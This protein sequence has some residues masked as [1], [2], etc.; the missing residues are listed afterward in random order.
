MTTTKS[1][2]PKD[3]KKN[4]L[5]VDA[6]DQIV[7]RLATQ[8]AYVLRGKHKPTYTPHVDC[9]DNVVIINAEKIRFTGN[10]WKA[11]EYYHHS[12]FI[13]GIK[14]ARAE[15]LRATKPERILEIA[16]KGMLPKNKLGRHISSN[17]KVYAGTE[18]PHAAQ[19][20]QPIKPRTATGE[21]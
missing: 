3:V 8:V 2:N 13:G 14:T 11:K 6:T 1:I 9:G 12:G 18:H 17:L 20:P 5:L 15:E 10:K 21:K 16:I 19:N 4:W 7:G